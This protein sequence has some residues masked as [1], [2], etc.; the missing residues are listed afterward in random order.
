MG[1]KKWH[2]DVLFWRLLVVV[3]LTATISIFSLSTLLMGL[4]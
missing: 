1:E 4:L 2:E 3:P